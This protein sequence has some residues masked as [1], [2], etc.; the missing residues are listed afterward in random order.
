MS[1]FITER[2]LSLYRDLSA[3]DDR[4][5]QMLD[6]KGSRQVNNMESQKGKGLYKFFYSC[7]FWL[8]PPQCRI[9]EKH[10][11][12]LV[13]SISKPIQFSSKE[14][15]CLPLPYENYLPQKSVFISTFSKH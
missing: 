8:F 2:D 5:G 10:Q 7:E 1:E 11:G 3:I 6:S 4:G 13:I 15:K 12:V 9:L 14:D